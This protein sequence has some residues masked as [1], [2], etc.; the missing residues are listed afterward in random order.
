MGAYTAVQ[1]QLIESLNKVFN[2][3]NILGSDNSKVV[4]DYF[5]RQHRTLQQQFMK[6]VIVPVLQQ[7]AEAH[8]E[9]LVDP[10]NEYA[11]KLATKMLENVTEDDLYLP[12]I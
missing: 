8:K 9:K 5:G 6:V 7:L 12:L 11:A 1:E 10:R 4:R 3:L 2:A